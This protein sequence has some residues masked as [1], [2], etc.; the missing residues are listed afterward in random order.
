MKKIWI[1]KQGA[2][3]KLIVSSG[4]EH[5][6]RWT[7]REKGA[8]V[9]FGGSHH[10]SVL[11]FTI[12]TQVIACWVLHRSAYLDLYHSTGLFIRV[13]GQNLLFLFCSLRGEN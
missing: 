11:L 5:R 9:A 12:C 8:A 10:I 13:R 2:M 6:V 1:V 7:C 4:E 3:H